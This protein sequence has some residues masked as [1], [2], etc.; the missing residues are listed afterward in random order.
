MGYPNNNLNYISEVAKLDGKNISGVSVHSYVV[1]GAPA[2]P[3]AAEFLANL[4]GKYSLDNS[5]TEARGYLASA[6]PKCNLK[7]FVT[8]ANGAEVNAFTQL[9]PTFA[10]TTYVAADA[11]QALNLRVTNLDWFAYDSSYPGAWE[12]RAGPGEQYTLMSQ[13]MNH[14][15][16]RTLATTVTGPSLFFA[17]ATYGS[18]S[19]LALLMVNA[20]VTQSLNVDLSKAGILAGAS[21]HVEQWKNGSV[22]PTNSSLTFLTSITIPAFSITILTVSPSGLDGGTAPTHH[23]RAADPRAAPHRAPSAPANAAPAPVDAGFADFP[24]AVKETPTQDT[25][26]SL[27]SGADNAPFAR[28]SD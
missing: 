16:P 21:V 15:G 9:L 11:V 3:T 6:C 8:E 27:A 1:G 7:V 25:F 20:N 17:V 23:H 19:G 18:S 10:G 13:M 26:F 5:V 14:L 12:T 24:F 22:G 2:H 4:N 28:G